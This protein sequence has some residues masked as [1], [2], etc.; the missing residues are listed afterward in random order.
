M[1]STIFL[2]TVQKPKMRQ[3]QREESAMLYPTPLTKKNTRGRI[4]W[5]SFF[6]TAHARFERPEQFIR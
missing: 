1:M 6:R 5:L 2:H 4:T 3:F